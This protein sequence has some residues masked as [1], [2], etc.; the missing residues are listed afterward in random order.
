MLT[1]LLICSH[2]AHSIKKDGNHKPRNLFIV[3]FLSGSL[4]AV[5]TLPPPPFLVK[6]LPGPENHR[7]LRGPMHRFPVH[8][9]LPIPRFFLRPRP[10]PGSPLPPA[11]S[12]EEAC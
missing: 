3:F 12:V 11:S 7:C 9:G 4:I 2:V 5:E 8:D 1:I 6:F 10:R